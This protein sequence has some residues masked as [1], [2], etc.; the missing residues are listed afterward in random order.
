[1]HSG[2]VLVALLAPALADA[3]TLDGATL[4]GWWGAPFAGLLLSIALGPLL[5]PGLWHRHYGKIALAWALAFVVPCALLVGVAP[6]LAALVHVLLAEYVPFIILLVTLF[7]VAGGIH[8]RGN[9]HGSPL[10]N[11]ALLLVGAVLA[12]F[13]GTTGAAMLMIRPLLR[14]NDNRRSA[15]HVV[16][17]F[18]FIVANAGGALTPLGDPPL[19]LGFLAGVDFSWPVRHVLLHTLFLVGALLA[20]FLAVD[21]WHYRREG[22]LRT[23]PTPDTKGIAIEG[24]RNVLLLLA[25]MGLV[26]LSG[27]WHPGIAW[28]VL[29][30]E[31]RLEQVV[32]DVLLLLVAGAS[33]RWTPERVHRENEF[34]WA[35]MV[36]VAR[37]FAAIFVTLA[38]VIAILRAGSAGAFAPIVA[39][40]T[41]AGGQPV[42]AAY[43][44]ASGL[45]S[46]FLDNAPTYLVFF[47]LAGGDPRVLMTTAAPVLAAISIGSVFMGANSY[48]GNAPN[49]MVKAVAEHRGVKMPGFFG[50]MGW[51]GAVLLPLFAVIHWLF[52]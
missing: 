9:L 37:L 19:F 36:E 46:S 34:A 31:F 14:A 51:A 7:A 27:V 11:A 49:L 10:L 13:M 39:L 15:A 23:D 12:S 45:L 25:V 30:T 38:P 18:I 2:A 3:A 50:Y 6:M 44:W 29:G 20:I 26:L 16:V 24:W 47:N 22:V 1:M 28:S 5:L 33:L 32:R 35:P 41:D 42:P 8:V 52:F 4:G 48:I 21:S 43:F 17:F 40:V